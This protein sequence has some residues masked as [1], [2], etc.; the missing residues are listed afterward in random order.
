MAAIHY[1][2]H[3]SCVA[4]HAVSRSSQILLV[5]QQ[6]C[7]SVRL[8]Q[9][10]GSMHMQL[11]PHLAVTPFLKLVSHGQTSWTSTNDGDPGR[12]RKGRICRALLD[13]CDFMVAT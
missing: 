6:Q 7:C 11:E 2:T 5:T 8:E 13:L 12:L 10:I 3:S 1:E 9:P 4:Q